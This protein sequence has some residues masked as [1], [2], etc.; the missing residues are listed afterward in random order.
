MKPY[1]VEQFGNASSGQHT[2]GW[3]ASEAVEKAREQVAKLIG[4]QAKEITF[5]SGATESNALA[6][7]GFFEG[8]VR[9]DRRVQ[10]THSHHM[11]TTNVEHKAVL[12]NA[13]I[14]NELY[15]TECSIVKARTD[16]SI[17]VE[18]LLAQIKEHTRLVSVMWAN[19]EVGTVQAIEDLALRLQQ[20]RPDVIFHSDAVQAAAYIDIDVQK[21]NVDMLSLSAHKMYGP[22]G[23]GA[24]YL[25]KK[26]PRT[27][28]APQL[29]GGGQEMGLRSGTLNVA[30]IVG[31]GAAAELVQRERFE[32]S[33]RLSDLRDYFTAQLLAQFPFARL[34][35]ADLSKGR[36]PHNVS[37]TF[38][39]VNIVDLIAKMAP[40]AALSTGSACASKTAEPSHVLK[41]L[42]LSDEEARQTVRFGL[43]HSSTKAALDRV[44]E[45]LKACIGRSQ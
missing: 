19:N 18:H 21:A 28:L 20:I 3:R 15:G 36:L 40:I 23:I 1:L 37:I 29:V 22:K 5:T 32:E 16:G 13:K 6:I 2:Y 38:K 43:G 45:A 8:L 11:V 34:N 31:M 30:G 4:A 41:A 33:A 26:S 44:L 17:L 14:C 24:L 42:G 27:R 12:E 10:Q 39:G 9:E 35:G 7:R 25:K